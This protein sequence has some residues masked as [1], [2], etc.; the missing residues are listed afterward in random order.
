MIVKVAV[1][2]WSRGAAC[3]LALG[4]SSAIV[5]SIASSRATI[6][7]LDFP[8]SRPF[9]RLAGPESVRRRPPIPSSATPYSDTR[10]PPAPCQ[11]TYSRLESRRGPTDWGE[12]NAYRHQYEALLTQRLVGAGFT[13]A[14]GSYL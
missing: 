4:N 11:L 12:Q 10:Q 13:P 3:V 9:G 7:C 6:S 8:G 14:L 1:F 2:A 5:S